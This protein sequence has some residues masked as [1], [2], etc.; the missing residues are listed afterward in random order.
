[1]TTATHEE[2][3]AILE[4]VRG[5]R[6]WKDLGAF[7]VAIRLDGSRCSVDNPRHITAT[8]SVQDLARGFARFLHDARALREWAFVVEAMDVDL[9]VEGRP[10]GET[11]L[12]ALWDASLGNPIDPKKIEAI[13]QLA[14]ED[15]GS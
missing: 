4:V 10:G 8:A 6:P 2:Q 7:G 13:L 9:A 15:I 14:K 12:D 1:L 3:E 11:L 5:S